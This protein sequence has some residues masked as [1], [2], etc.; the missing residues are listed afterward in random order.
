MGDSGVPPGGLKPHTEALVQGNL[1]RVLRERFTGEDALLEAATEMLFLDVIEDGGVPKDVETARARYEPMLSDLDVLPADE[2]AAA[3]AY[4]ALLEGVNDALAN[5]IDEEE[6]LGDDACEMCERVMP[7][8]RHHLI[9]R[10]EWK[11]FEKRPPAG[12]AESGRSLQETAALCRQCHSAVHSFA[13]ERALVRE[14]VHGAV[15]L[16]T[17]RRRLLQTPPALG[18]A[19][20]WPLLEIL[21]LAARNQVVP[22]ERH[23]PLAHLA[24]VVPQELFFVNLVRQRVV[25]ALEQRLVRVRGGVLVRGEHVEV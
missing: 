5:E 21:P 16:T 6:L 4:E 10:S 2:D 20:R 17:Q 11:Y 18:E 15:A 12:F 13:D 19:G 9:P 23:D 24:R 3:D 8:T 7:L 1:A 25:H 22:G 14:R